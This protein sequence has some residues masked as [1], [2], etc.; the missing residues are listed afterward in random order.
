MSLGFSKVG[1]GWQ[2]GVPSGW[3]TY[4]VNLAVELAKR[5]IEPALFLLAAKLKLTEP[6]IALMRPL[7]AK[8][9]E[10]YAA[11]AAGGLQLDFPMLHPMSD[12][13]QFH[14]ILNGLR[15]R[16]NVAVPFFESAVIPPENIEAAKQFDLV[17]AGST[18]NAEMLNKHG[19]APPVRV[20]LQGVDLELF[21]PGPKAGHFGDRFVVFSGGKL[22][23]RKGQDLV[24][25]A[26]KQFHAKRPEALLVTA[27]H[28]PWPKVAEGLKASP[29]VVATAGVKADGT[30]DVSSWLV[31]NGLPP[32]AFHDV[33]T[34]PN[35][36][37]PQLMREVDLAVFPNRCEG[38]TNLVAMEAMACGVPV[39]LARNTGHLDLIR[40]D[41]CY[42]LDLQIP[43]G[44]V[45][46]RPDLEGWGESSVDELA[47]VMERAYADRQDAQR[48]GA[49]AA[50]FMKNWGWNTQVEHLL[51]ALNE[52]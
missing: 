8:Q 22:E 29:H 52:C 17:V 19:I 25:A 47:A 4:G 38:G 32:G 48:R 18:W 21:S 35:A 7:V 26:F 10:W 12:G 49:A 41:N 11:A 36:A 51:V 5:D 2:I 20:C 44:E 24:V 16:P 15:G 13:F 28:S 34:M 40:P 14:D 23:Y 45:T 3:G 6:Q 50:A 39:A 42:S 30:L 9:R 37:A 1:I 46:K 33:G 43:I 31:A 27:W